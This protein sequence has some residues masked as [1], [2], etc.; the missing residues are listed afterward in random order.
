MLTSKWLRANARNLILGSCVALVCIIF[1]VNQNSLNSPLPTSAFMHNGRILTSDA[2]SGAN[3]EIFI[4]PETGHKNLFPLNST[5]Y[6]ATSLVVIGL[7]IAASGGIGGGGLLVPIFIIIWD[8][9]PIYAIA[10]SNFT[11]LGASIMNMIMNLSKRHPEVDRPLIDWDLIMMMEPVTMAGAIFGAYLGKLLPEVFLVT[12]LVLLLGY[13]SKTTLEKGFSLWN[14]ET[15]A[16]RLLEGNGKN[17]ELARAVA[18]KEEED[19]E[20]EQTALLGPADRAAA[21]ASV[22]ASACDT[23]TVASGV[24]GIGGL[25]IDMEEGQGE[26]GSERQLQADAAELAAMY[27]AERSTPLEPVVWMVGMFVVV[28]IL[29]LLKGGN[30]GNA[31][32]SPVGIE[33]GSTAYWGVTVSIF[34][35]VLGVSVIMREKMVAK[36]HLKKRLRYKYQPGD[37]EWNEYNTIKYPALCILAGLSAGMFGIGGGIVKGPLMLEMGV[38]PLV[39]AA[40][41]AVMIFFTSIAATSSYVA[42]GILIWDY[43]WYLFVLGLAA[44]LIGQFGVS[45]LVQKYKRVSLVSLSIGAVVSISTVLMAF[46][47]IYSLL[48]DP[49]ESEASSSICGN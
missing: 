3:T 46:Q 7:M 19:G 4:N 9:K 28:I 34:V 2:S 38:S 33:C 47:S 14:K 32:P 13:T 11:I 23:T 36:F 31:F 26:Q 29:N 10:L 41:V 49:S 8:F 20:E 6:F 12:S 30:G 48:V 45:Y 24:A 22:S 44:T 21:S 27:D 40:T 18:S 16:Q 17:S 25:E 39:A 15:A 37:V 5:D 35:F 1:I 42:F 43:G